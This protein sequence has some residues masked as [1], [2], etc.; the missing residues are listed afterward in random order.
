VRNEKGLKLLL[1]V[2]A[3]NDNQRPAPMLQDRY[4]KDKFFEYVFNLAVEMDPVLAEIDRLLEDEALYQL[5]RTDF[6]KRHPHTATTGRKSTPVEVLLRMLVVRRLY[7]WSYEETEKRVKDSLVLRW[8]CRVYFEAV[9]DDTTLIKWA[10]LVQPETLEQFNRR[11]TT[12][13]TQLKVTRGRKLR[14]D[15]TVVETNIQTPSDSRLLADSVRVLGRTLSRAKELLAGETALKK[16]VFRNRLRSAKQT[17]HQAQRLMGRNQDLGQHAYQKL[18]R[19]THKTVAQVKKVLA[20]LKDKTEKQAQQLVETFETFLPRAE[21]VLDQT[22]RRVFQQERV[23]ADEKTV[24]IFE[25]HTDII[26]R[27]KVG[28][29]VEYGRKVWLDEVEGG[30]VSHWRVLDGNPNDKTQ[31]I[32]SLDAHE[33][34]FDKPPAQASADRGVYSADNQKEAEDRG[35]KRIVLPKPG[36]KSAKRQT[37]EKQAW[38]RRGRKWHAGVEGRISVLKR[39]FG[40]DR[41]RNQGEKGFQRWVG[42]AVIA[43]NLRSVGTHQAMRVAKAG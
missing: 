1:E 30:I 7:S 43:N 35:I 23:P 28:K 11:L 32:P 4:E 25:P 19:I 22:V 33:A 3:N 14:T 10:G 39:V 37:Y 24:S 13:A 29:S 18:V 40:L 26:C 36:K 12:L 9:P 27:G 2:H 21:Q 41:C 5:I 34:Q 20:V 42:W 17:A 38:F 15:G 31:W 16:A 6:A 8:F